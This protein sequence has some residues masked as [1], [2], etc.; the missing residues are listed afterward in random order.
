MVKLIKKDNMDF[1][2]ALVFVTFFLIDGGP[3]TSSDEGIENQVG[4]A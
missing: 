1:N 3:G 4:T 2:I